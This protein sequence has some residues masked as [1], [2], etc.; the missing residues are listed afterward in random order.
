[1]AAEQEQRVSSGAFV[2]EGG[3]RNSRAYKASVITPS[4]FMDEMIAVLP[5]ATKVDMMFMYS[6]AGEDQP[7]ETLKQPLVGTATSAVGGVRLVFSENHLHHTSLNPKNFRR[8]IEDIRRNAKTKGLYRELDEQVGM[9]VFFS[10]SQGAGKRVNLRGRA[11]NVHSKFVQVHKADKVIT[12][13]PEF[14]LTRQHLQ[15]ENNALRIEESIT[16]ANKPESVSSRVAEYMRRI[17]DNEEFGDYTEKIDD[18]LEFIADSGKRRESLIQD[19]AVALITDLSTEDIY[20]AS[21]YPPFVGPTFEAL[22][23]KASEGKQVFIRLPYDCL[24]GRYKRFSDILLRRLKGVENNVHISYCEPTEDNPKGGVHSKLLLVNSGMQLSRDKKSVV[25]KPY[26]DGRTGTALMT[27]NNQFPVGEVLGTGE[28][29]FIITDPELIGEIG[30]Q[31]ARTHN[32]G[33]LAA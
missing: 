31:A 9:D 28:A 33:Y 14:N 16:D 24:N 22:R 12:Y 13:M 30:Q 1:M 25:I 20:F 15:M 19:T 7:L 4:Q 17:R 27:S 21:Q 18:G 26:A 11:G 2:P 10:R 29:G 5:T 8:I 32:S 3:E 23:Q 6:H